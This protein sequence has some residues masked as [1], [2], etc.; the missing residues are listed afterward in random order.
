[1]S[2]TAEEQVALGAFLTER[3]R[4][5]LDQAAVKLGKGVEELISD[6]ER[7]LEG[8]GEIDEATR[9]EAT[10][11]AV[12]RWVERA[13]ATGAVRTT[14]LNTRSGRTVLD[15]ATELLARKV[16]VLEAAMKTGKDLPVQRALRLAEAAAAVAVAA[17][18]E[19]AAVEGWSGI[20]IEERRRE[21][22]AE[23]EGL[24]R[25]VRGDALKVAVASWAVRVKA[26]AT[27]AAAD[28]K[29]VIEE[30]SGD[31][32]REEADFYIQEYAQQSRDLEQLM[33]EGRAAQYGGVALFEETRI[34]VAEVL[35]AMKSAVEWL[36]GVRDGLP[37]T[38]VVERQESSQSSG[39]QVLLG[40]DWLADTMSDLSV[41][42]SAGAGAPVDQIAMLARTQAM[43]SS[44]LQQ[45]AEG[46]CR[47]TDAEMKHR[48]KDWP[49][50]D[51]K[52]LNYVA[53]KR[54]WNQH[55]MENYPG[56]QGDSL[57]RILVERS[58]LPVDKDRVRYKPSLKE[59]W[60]YL[61]R[62]YIR[63]DTFLHD[64]MK[65]VLSAKEIGDRNFRGLEEYM[66]LLIRTF[67]I[68]KD[69][70]MLDI[71][72]HINNMRPMFEKWPHA[73]QTRWWVKAAEMTLQEQPAAFRRHVRERY[74]VVAT[75]AS[76]AAIS[77]HKPAAE[78]KEVVKATG[79]G[80][81]GGF[82]KGGGGGFGKGKGGGQE[83]SAVQKATVNAVGPTKEI[84]KLRCK[85]CG[86]GH[87]VENCPE[88]KK[89]SSE[90]RVAAV[91]TWKTCKICMRHPENLECFKKNRP[92]YAGCTV[93]GCK[94]DHHVLLHWAISIARMFSISVEP[95]SY[96]AG[97]RV[98]H[99]RQRIQIRKVEAGISFDGGSDT[100][101]VAQ[102][103]VDRLKLKP[104]GQAIRMVGFGQEET[105]TGLVYEVPLA[106]QMKEKFLVRA[107]AVDHIPDHPAAYTPSDAHFRFN[108]LF[109]WGDVHQPGGR[110]DICIGMDL[111]H[112]QPRF[113]EQEANGGPL[114]VYRSMFGT[115]WILRGVEPPEEVFENVRAAR[116]AVPVVEE[117][118]EEMVAVEIVGAAR[119]AVPMDV[120]VQPVPGDVW[121]VRPTVPEDVEEQPAAEGDGAARAAVP[122]DVE[123]QPVQEDVG[124][125][126]PTVPEDVE[127]QP[128]AEGDGAARAAVPVDVEMQPVRGDVWAV[129]QTVA[130]DVEEEPGGE[131]DGEARA[132]V[133]VDVEMQPVPGDVW[134]VR[135]TVPEDV[136][137]QPA[138]EGDGAARSAVPVD[139]EMQP[140]A[141]GDGA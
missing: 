77:G 91:Q 6:L 26:V 105:A 73:E 100:T 107:V 13:A 85:Q 117:V 70:G 7:Y 115:G 57:K 141:E 10:K 64:L 52:T 58:L 50:F 39:V 137:E 75:I 42:S 116:P 78:K 125:V 74:Q 12:G 72:L 127:E 90:Q 97:T 138:A 61:D 56:L 102:A 15:G 134:A 60:E 87:G 109:K 44:S 123:M 23:L 59:V 2:P 118:E 3:Q 129:R 36:A 84:Q 92:D 95:A 46:L 9:L 14:E 110:T 94:D 135:P 80:G 28:A 40:R 68:A 120:E 16:V 4:Q 128:A 71:V 25:K 112:L 101:V 67:D 48:S 29:E 20:Q 140:A 18:K 126:R 19:K 89:M 98:Y 104:V 119:P 136:E 133:P 53:W 38:A 41:N 122:V 108:S 131:G 49:V 93:P 81:G 76:Q 54:E 114:R 21:M 63:H 17:L 88:F 51:G 130:G 45:V 11:T 62:T 86:E 30:K 65:P 113:V 5:N 66:D 124:A 1:M 106:T 69:A 103:F 24:A 22:V 34:G 37:P 139:E 31:Y 99:L 43:T 96:P 111:A 83:K 79:G 132:A 32:T 35:V 8:L 47:W 33:A 27:V 121:A 55:H 82:G